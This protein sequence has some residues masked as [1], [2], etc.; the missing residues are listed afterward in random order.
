[1]TWVL[2]PLETLLLAACLIIQAGANA[3]TIYAWTVADEIVKFDTN[4]PGTV[5]LVSVLT[6]LPAGLNNRQDLAWNPATPDVLYALG[7]QLGFQ[8]FWLLKIDIDTGVIFDAPVIGSGIGMSG[9]T[10]IENANYTGLVAAYRPWSNQE[11]ELCKLDLDGILSGCISTGVDNQNLTWDSRDDILYSRGAPAFAGGQARL[12][13]IPDFPIGTQSNLGAIRAGTLAYSVL[14]DRIYNYE[15][16]S[17]ELFYIDTT[18][19]GA[20]IQEVSLGIVSGNPLVS[21]VV[22]DSAPN[23]G[24]KHADIVAANYSQGGSQP[25]QVCFGYGTAEFNC[26][27]LPA[28]SNLSN[29]V[30]VG[31]VNGDGHADAV[32][33]VEWQSKFTVC[34]GDGSRSLTCND[35]STGW[36]HFLG[37]ALGD[38]N[39]DGNLDALLANYARR[40]QVCLGDGAGGFGCSDVS[41]DTNQSYTVALGYVD[42]DANLDAVF[43]NRAGRNRVCLGDGSGGFSCA[44]VNAD[45]RFSFGVALG[46]VNGDSQLDAVFANHNLQFNQV[47]LGDGTGGFTCADVSTDANS[48]HMV[49]LGDVNNDGDLD[50]V[51]A[52]QGAAASRVCLG[53]GT[54]SFACD[55]V[56]SS[57][58]QTRDVA[59]GYINGDRYLDLVFT[60]NGSVPPKYGAHNLICVGDGTGGFSCSSIADGGYQTRGIALSQS[61]VD[62]DGIYDLGDNCPIDSNPDQIDSNGDGYGDACVDPTVTIPDGANVDPAVSIGPN[63]KI[64]VG[65]VIEAEADLGTSVVVDR[66]SSIG[67]STAIGDYTE[68]RKYTVIGDNVSI[69]NDVLIGSGVIIED[70]VRIGN[71]S[72]LNKNVHIGEGAVIGAE[73]DIGSYTTILAHAVVLDGTIIGKNQV[74]GP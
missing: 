19:G 35:I 32:F 39:A 16:V 54:G 61:D 11:T 43:A 4:D 22:T 5:Q 67:K 48:S 69:G 2:K 62:G 30:A 27:N 20:P 26:I 46:D 52:N 17:H 74:V 34:L 70:N 9:L 18:D 12:W 1:M 13:A 40:N 44:D 50:A 56:T 58:Y 14:D 53:N 23:L 10:Y 72:V 73:C 51:F 25:D 29:D 57:V 21:M 28:P 66:N 49:A 3:A 15:H 6:G 47:C 36:S 38:V 64:N 71:H 33:A 45:T 31:D 37:V 55:D 7:H 68:I 24:D 42:G 41:S 63:S 59:L 65:V 8:N 60:V